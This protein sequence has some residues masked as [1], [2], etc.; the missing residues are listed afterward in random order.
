MGYKTLSNNA[1][2]GIKGFTAFAATG[3][4]VGIQDE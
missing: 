1:N 3:C 4:D 2:S